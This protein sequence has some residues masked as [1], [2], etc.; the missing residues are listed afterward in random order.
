VS[1]PEIDIAGAKAK[2]DA[3][4]ALFVD[5][6]DPNSRAAA[7]I[8]GSVPLSNANLAAFIEEQPR[9]REIIVYCYHGNSSRGATQY[10]I[11]QGFSS[12]VSM[13]GGFEAWRPLYEAA[14]DSDSDSDGV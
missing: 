3:G 8:P 10:L 1:V 5:I 6:R 14:S 4:E 2:L 11:E 12:V 7:H 13:S 9:E